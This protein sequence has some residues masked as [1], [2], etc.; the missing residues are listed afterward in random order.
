MAKLPL[1]G[2]RT[3]H[4]K[5]L[6][7]SLTYCMVFNFET[8]LDA[9]NALGLPQA[10]DMTPTLR[11][12]KPCVE[13]C[14]AIGTYDVEA[15]REVPHGFFQTILDAAQNVVHTLERVVA[16]RLSGN[17]D[18]QNFNQITESVPNRATSWFQSLTVTLAYLRRDDMDLQKGIQALEK[19]RAATEGIRAETEK[20]LK[21]LEAEVSMRLG[22]VDKA[23]EAAHRAALLEGVTKQGR[24]FRFARRGHAKEANH[25]ALGAAVA[26][27][28]I[29]AGCVWVYFCPHAPPLPDKSWM[30][31]ANLSYFGVRVLLVSVLSFIMV[32]SVRN[33]RGARHNEVMNA[34]R[35]RALATFR[36]FTEG[37]DPA[38]VQAVTL[39]AAQAIFG[40]QP[41]AYA[42]PGPVGST[43]FAELLAAAQERK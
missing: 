21:D 32:V 10:F 13:L 39:Q 3:N 36:N 40:V 30:V 4:L 24:E 28:F 6:K 12:L 37:A 43:H 7:Q 2:D 23:L 20:T 15:L 14:R 29:V 38:V 11:H 5:L 26:G 31:A 19:Q 18:Q 42:E 8:T 9:I 1:D 35:A 22:A 33:Y 34:H 25:W 41:S 16:F 27:S 17:S